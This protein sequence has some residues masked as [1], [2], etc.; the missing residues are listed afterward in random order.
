MASESTTHVS[1]TRTALLFL[2]PL[3]LVV[4]VFILLPILGTFWNSFFLDV[5]FLP[6]RFVGLQNYVFIFN[7]PDFRQA[8]LFTLSFAAVAVTFEGLLGLGFALLLNES[9]PGRWF[10]RT[11]I[12]IPWAVPTIVSA[13][14]WKLIYEYSYGVLNVLVT[15][16]GLSADRINWLGTELSA[17]FALIAAD[18][19]KTT[20]F[21]TLIVLAGLQ[22]I[23]D[24]LYEQARIDGANTWNRFRHVTLPMIQPVLIIALIFRTIDSLRLFD[25]VYV[26]TG[27]GPGGATRT[28]SVIGFEAFTND[29]FGLGSAMSVVAFLVAFSVTLVYV[30]AS[31]LSERLS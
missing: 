9:F 12:L 4:G 30:R 8:F 19:W 2:S 24:S 27:G 23:P 3:L 13:K 26:L 14:T 1:E 5:S 28:L 29:R 16:F 17:F 11:L 22:T 25:L 31:R 18:V 7:D 10:L 21:V 20:P 15:G 6:R